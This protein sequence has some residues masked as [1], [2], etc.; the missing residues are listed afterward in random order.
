MKLLREPLV[1]FLALGAALFALSALF[2]G[3][4]AAPERIVVTRGRVEHLAANFARTWQRPPT[5]PELQG[6]V[7]AW[8]REEIYARE[9]R[10]LGLDLDDAVIRR[11]LWQ[12]MEFLVEEATPPPSEAELQA[13]LEEHPDAF[14][15]EP[16]LS[17]RQVYVSPDRRGDGAATDAAALLA[18]LRAA[19]PDAD[20]EGD[21]LGVPDELQLVPR[22][23]ITRLF[24]DVF[25][26]RLEGVEPGAWAGPIESGYGLHLVFVREHVDGRLPALAEVRDAVEREW[27]AARR[28][29]QVEAAY[30]ERRAR[31][32]VVIEAPPSSPANV[33]TA[34]GGG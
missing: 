8:V 21:R 17:F 20:V 28:K 6:L 16:R 14:R 19:G 24:G 5:P 11:R 31:Y 33:A 7:D 15:T 25:A 9:A 1:H 29:A 32:T 30:Q 12:K 13:Y 18:R 23:E 27:L 34:P 4:G 2:G 3:R 10:A 22:S 26:A